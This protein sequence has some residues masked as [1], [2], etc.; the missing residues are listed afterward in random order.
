M[1]A[2][3]NRPHYYLYC[4]LL[5][6]HLATAALKYGMHPMSIASSKNTVKALR[7]PS[8]SKHTQWLHFC[9]GTC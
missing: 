8:L 7:E 5:A 6:C 4:T 3:T 2:V 1:L 9:R